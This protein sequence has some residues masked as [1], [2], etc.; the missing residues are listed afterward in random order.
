MRNISF[1]ILLILITA[2]KGFD[3]SPNES[4]VILAGG[5]SASLAHGKV[6]IKILEIGD[7]RCP[8]DVVCIWEG[9]MTVK[10]K[11]TAG[12]ASEE[13]ELSIPEYNGKTRQKELTVGS[14][15]LKV[16]LKD[17]TPYPCIN[18][19]RQEPSRAFIEVEKN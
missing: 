19:K 2:C 18:C 16:T 6:V 17:V 10:L 9:M 11:V 13:T 3:L 15:P 8:S 12:N 1:L 7:G 4:L 5:E 14:L